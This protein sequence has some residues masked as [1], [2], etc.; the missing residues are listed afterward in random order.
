MPDCAACC[1]HL[2]GAD[3]DGLQKHP[4]HSV[5]CVFARPRQD[6]PA[7]R[8][9]RCAVW[10]SAAVPHALVERPLWSLRTDCCAEPRWACRQCFHST[11]LPHACHAVHAVLLGLPSAAAATHVR[12]AAA[13]HAA[14]R[15]SS[16][17]FAMRCPIRPAPS[18][19]VCSR[20]GAVGHQVD[21]LAAQPGRQLERCAVQATH[22]AYTS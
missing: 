9:L 20:S 2:P 21:L 15:L 1:P 17:L 19:N 11:V 16:Y 22:G 14:I 3:L 7:W 4:R 5:L 13:L 8:R 10:L 12:H 18:C 6:A